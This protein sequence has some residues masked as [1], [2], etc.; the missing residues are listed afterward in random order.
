R[1]KIRL[2]ANGSWDPIN[3]GIALSQLLRYDI[4]LVED[5]VSS[6]QDMARLRRGSPIM[7][8]AEMCVRTIEDARRLR[9]LG[10][11]DAVVLKPQR[12]GGVRAALAAAEE[13]G[14]PA[15]ASSALESSVG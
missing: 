12:I 8:A 6:M 7:I 1:A 13:A 15:I 11:A 10:A 3:A 14:V 9:E 5:P 4:E 2:D